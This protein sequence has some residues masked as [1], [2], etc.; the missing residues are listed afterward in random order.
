MVSAARVDLSRV[1][2]KLQSA[3]TAT[4]VLTPQIAVIEEMARRAAHDLRAPV[5]QIKSFA[6][7][8]LEDLGPAVTPE[9]ARDIQF[10]LQ[11]AE[12][13]QTL[14]DGLS[15]LAV[16]S[17]KDIELSPI[18]VTNGLP[19]DHPGVQFNIPEPPPLVLAD[20][21]LL[22]TMWQQALLAASRLSV[23]QGSIEV[24]V[25]EVSDDRTAIRVLLAESGLELRDVINALQPFPALP[26]HPHDPG[27]SLAICHRIAERMG[28]EMTAESDPGGALALHMILPSHEAVAD[29]IRFPS[30]F[31]APPVSR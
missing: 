21:E 31:P 29:E 30:P 7:F 3:T 26:G 6:G 14:I 28:G 13:L 15:D 9:A 25:Q 2:P 12:R 8:L 24:S 18:P 10:I 22:R 19:L 20:I 17:A 1:R 27:S 23:G 11:G 16:T 5:R 4:P